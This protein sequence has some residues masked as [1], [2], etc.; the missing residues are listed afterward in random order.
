MDQIKD[1]KYFTKMDVRWGDNNVRIH[2]G[3]EWKAVFKTKYG[4]FE[5]LVMFVGLCNSPATF[6]HMMD[7]IF[8]IKL[9]QGL[10]MIYMDDIL[11]PAD[12]LE[13]LETLSKIVLQKLKDND[14]YL[15]PEKC[16]FAR[17]QIE[18]LGMII[19]QGK[20]RMDPK[21]VGGIIKWPEPK[22]VTQ[23]ISFLGFGNFYRRFIRKYSEVVKPL[24]DF[25]RK[26][27]LSY[28]QAKPKKPLT[29]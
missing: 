29:I 6:Q 21:K 18:Y 10:I 7:D 27:P 4:L 15:K 19:E 14:L 3:D 20:L 25:S 26:T 9:K 23:V 13:E 8:A 5:P 11:I 16:E 17:T 12:A 28:G 24:N 1:K 2:K 22:N